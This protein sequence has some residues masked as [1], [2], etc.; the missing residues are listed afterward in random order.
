ME[1]REGLEYEEEVFPGVVWQIDENPI[2][3]TICDF[4]KTASQG[5]WGKC[6][7]WIERGQCDGLYRAISFW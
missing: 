2:L 7:N 3:R 4:M 5:Q 6:K 1:C